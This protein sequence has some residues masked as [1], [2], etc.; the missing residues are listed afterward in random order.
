MRSVRP[1]SAKGFTL[2]EVLVGMAILAIAMIAAMRALANSADA[3]RVI[4]ERKA[5]LR[6]ADNALILL[7]INRSWPEAGTTLHPC[8]QGQY[9]L[10]CQQKVSP[11]QNPGFRRV[12]VTVRMAHDRDPAAGRGTTLARLTTA[13]ANPAGGLF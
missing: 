11:M 5:A 1:K 10:V 12:E 6:S 7:R 2:I 3:A 4:S 13:I 8:P 9:A